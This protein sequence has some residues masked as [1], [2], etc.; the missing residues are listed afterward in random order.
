MI[1]SYQEIEGDFMARVYARET[2]LKN[3]VG[4]SDYIT[5]PDRQEHIVLT[6]SH[7]Q[8]TW[9][10]YVEFEKGNKKS[11]SENIQAR[12]T[13]IALPND[14]ST[15]SKELE[16]FCDTLGKTLYGSNRD[17]EYA[18]HWNKDKTNLH[19]H[20][21]YSERE[22]NTERQPKTYKRDMWVDSKTGRTCK[23]DNPNASLRYAKG[24]IQR[25]KEG[26]I[27][28]NT[29][30]FTVKDPKY[31][32]KNWLNERNLLIKDV[33]SR[34]ER[35]IDLFDRDKHIPQKKLYK[36]ARNDYKEYAET[37]NNN[38]KTINTS[39]QT[40]MNMLLKE[41]RTLKPLI[42]ALNKFDENEIDK[43]KLRLAVYDHNGY[44]GQTMNKFERVKYRV[45]QKENDTVTTKLYD[46]KYDKVKN[47]ISNS[48]LQKNI[49]MAVYDYKKFYK[50]ILK[51]IEL[52]KENFL[53]ARENIY[54]KI[55]TIEK[56]ENYKQEIV[57]Q[58]KKVKAEKELK[59]KEIEK[60]DLLQ[61][62]RKQL[63]QH[64]KS[65]KRSHN[66]ER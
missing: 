57:V 50:E 20:F 15:N 37:W 22:R 10:D 54:S 41:K 26:N 1:Y 66:F 8:N 38:A 46:E 32:N 44:A 29:D 39:R 13:V 56:L 35:R 2:A 65:K 42:E 27:K 58:Q 19:A 17:Y 45:F 23:A 55:G 43:A 4:R 36:G 6:K 51:R 24:D 59:L 25:D 31:N 64:K 47:A 61:K 34:F 14:L 62:Q 3:V 12:E 52:I 63:I 53:K 18:V 11:S 28:Y 49:H 30:Q 48:S 7:M 60:R 21:I 9:N 40:S 33:F 5:N 16:Q